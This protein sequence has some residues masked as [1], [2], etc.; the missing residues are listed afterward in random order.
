MQKGADDMKEALSQIAAWCFPF[1]CLIKHVCVRDGG[2][3]G[4]WSS[5]VSLNTCYFISCEFGL[6][7]VF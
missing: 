2:F 5:V 4:I 3:D 1:D 6:G 7:I